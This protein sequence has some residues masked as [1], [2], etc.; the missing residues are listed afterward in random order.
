MLCGRLEGGFI[1]VMVFLVLRARVYVFHVVQMLE[2]KW[3]CAAN[4]LDSWFS[5]KGGCGNRNQSRL[6]FE[7]LCANVGQR[8]SRP[9]KAIITFMPRGHN[10]R[11][12][13]VFVCC[14]FWCCGGRTP[15]RYYLTH[16][17]SL[18]VCYV[19]VSWLRPAMSRTPAVLGMLGICSVGGACTTN[20]Q[21]YRCTTYTRCVNAQ[22]G[23]VGGAA[24]SVAFRTLGW[25]D[26]HRH[27]SWY[28]RTHIEIY[29]QHGVV[30][31]NLGL[32]R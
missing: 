15:A 11:W 25:S 27:S 23:R 29:L 4:A 22:I 28:T 10:L 21:D 18:C 3:C 32:D 9:S 6:R 24:F 7:G 19:C 16:Y 1:Y 31:R 20:A 26:R 5:R 13:C 12:C 8:S 14:W 30:L 2:E 17:C